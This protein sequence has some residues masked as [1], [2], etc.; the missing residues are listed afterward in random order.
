MN[1]GMNIDF[2]VT[3]VDGNDPAWQ[4]E[5]I[6][7]RADKTTDIDA[8]RYRDMETLKYWFRAVEKYAPWVNKI[9]FVTWGCII[10]RDLISVMPEWSSGFSHFLQFQSEFG[11]KEFMI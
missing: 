4:K 8:A 6:Q 9:H 5:R 7:Y 2:V 1:E 11:N 3:W 10:L